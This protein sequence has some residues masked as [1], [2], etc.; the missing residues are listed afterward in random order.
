MKSKTTYA[1]Q[2]ELDNCLMLLMESAGK[3]TGNALSLQVI[4]TRL[5]DLKPKQKPTAAQ[6]RQIRSSVLRLRQEPFSV[7]I[8]TLENGAYFVCTSEDDFQYVIN[9]YK[10]SI[11]SYRATIRRLEA[12]KEALE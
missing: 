10:R 3:G 11:K 4:A 7:P 6:I 5:F 2:E 12:Q 1:E 9:R 8:Y